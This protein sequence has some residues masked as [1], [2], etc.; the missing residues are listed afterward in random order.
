MQSVALQKMLL[1]QLGTPF[2]LVRLS[3]LELSTPTS[4][5]TNHIKSYVL[6]FKSSCHFED[7]FYFIR[8]TCVKNPA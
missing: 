4:S 3:F 5:S 7:E 8:V 1:L 6:D 2:S